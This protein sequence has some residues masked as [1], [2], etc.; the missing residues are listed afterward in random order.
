MAC[1]KDTV[2]GPTLPA[3]LRLRSFDRATDAR[4]VDVITVL[5]ALSRRVRN[6]RQRPPA[7][8]P[9]DQFRPP[10]IADDSFDLAAMADDALIPSR[11]SFRVRRSAQP[12][13]I[14]S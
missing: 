14:K 6:A 10:R 8:P 2:V 3:A 5:Q 13:E 9:L 1:M 12:V 11:R 4:E 7:S